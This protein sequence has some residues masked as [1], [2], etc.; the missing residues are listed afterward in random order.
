VAPPEAAG[1]PPEAGAVGA[2][3]ACYDGSRV[4]VE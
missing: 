2:V 3:V 4:V 1:A